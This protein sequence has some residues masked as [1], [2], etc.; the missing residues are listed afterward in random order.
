[1]IIANGFLHYR[2]GS[3]T[4]LDSCTRTFKFLV[5]LGNKL[6]HLKKQLS[7]FEFMVSQIL[8]SQRHFGYIKL[9]QFINSIKHFWTLIIDLYQVDNAFTIQINS[10]HHC[11]RPLEREWC[12]KG[13]FEV[14][15]LHAPES[16]PILKV[17]S[18]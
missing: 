15:F 4:N 11:F 8:M 3:E 1:M 14:S 12:D 2:F 5:R 16:L 17:S 10:N 18:F 9:T 6:I 7:T 13:S